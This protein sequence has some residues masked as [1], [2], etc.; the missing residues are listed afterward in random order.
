M[1]VLVYSAITTGYDSIKPGRDFWMIDPA[2]VRSDDPCIQAKYPK[3]MIHDIIPGLA[4]SIWLDGSIRL[5]D[6]FNAEKVIE[7][8]LGDCDFA[9]MKHPERDCVYDE[10]V[11]CAKWNKD[12]PHLLAEQSVEYDR[13]G[14][15]RH[16]GLY[17]TGVMLRRHTR[18][19]NRICEHWWAEIMRYSRRDQVSLPFVVRQLGMKVGTIE[20]R[21]FF[22]VEKHT[23]KRAPIRAPWPRRQT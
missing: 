18:E 20:G 11:A 21:P 15:P 2:Y 5:N 22:T 1:Q 6:G 16:W 7:T 13:A 23:V 10:A 19:V 8:Y 9:V 3:I 14:H 4:Y 17:E 12:N